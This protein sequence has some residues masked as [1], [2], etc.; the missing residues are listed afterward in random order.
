MTYLQPDLKPSPRQN[1]LQRLSLLL[2]LCLPLIWL[3]G[4]GDDDA[5]DND[6][7]R[8]SIAVTWTAASEQ[9]VRETRNAVGSI[10][11][12]SA[13]FIAAEISGIIATIKVDEG[14]E[15][16]QGDLLAEIEADDYRD[17]RDSA[18]ADVARLT[19][20]VGVQERNVRRAQ[21]LYADDHISADEL[22]NA[23][24]DLESREQELT[25]ALANLRRAE[26]NL[27]RTRI[28]SGI[29]G[30]VSE[31]HVSAG[32]YAAAG[33]PLFDLTDTHNLKARIPVSERLAQHI[34][35]QTQLQLR[36]RSGSPSEYSAT[37]TN[38]RP[39]ISPRTRSLHLL[40]A[41]D[42]PGDWRPG[43]S[44]DAEVVLDVREQIVLPTQSV[45]R[46]PAGEVV[47]ILDDDEQAVTERTVETG[48]RMGDRIEISSGVESGERVVVDG[49][50]FL[51]D[52][53][54]VRAEEREDSESAT[55]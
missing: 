10:E 18:A 21:E 36:N 17:E 24:A 20:Q 41:I 7:G 46:R 14:D 32:D 6:Q 35:S 50:G 19:A 25:A 15:I 1:Q 16:E 52:G 34:D 33:D 4:C 45:V 28:R 44:I 39:N 13:P 26:R 40:A 3:S 43:A 37:V 54:E 48:T 8:P 38:M 42:N 12:L 2:A 31:R 23:E 51:T 11:P 53:A 55:E 27:E 9:Q 29:D 47:F 22:D 49:A 30:A 5:E